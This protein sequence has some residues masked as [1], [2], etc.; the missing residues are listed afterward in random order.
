MTLR[1]GLLVS[2][3]VT[4]GF[5]ATLT[6]ATELGP[7]PFDVLVNGIAATVGVSFAVALWLLAG[8][9]A[10]VSTALGKRPGPGTFLAPM[11]IGPIVGGLIGPL[12][13]L[14]D[15]FVGALFGAADPVGV[16]KLASVAVL[17]AVHLGG[18]LLI[19]FGA[20]AMII[21]GL[22]AG[23]G[24]LLAAATS[25]KLGRSMPVVRTALEVSFVGFGLMLGGPAGLGTV[26]VALSI[27][28]S[29]RFGHARMDAT[30]TRWADAVLVP[31]RADSV[32]KRS[33]GSLRRGR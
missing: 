26:L 19:G 18:V 31:T 4:I 9:L 23:T 10:I 20:G 11:I 29:V 14:L 8:L 30:L 21:S 27:G 1:L 17:S 3:A 13:S 5:G 24:D 7:G 22:G 12:T 25:S 6:M 33:V 32:V 28:P 15:S 2:G 16:E